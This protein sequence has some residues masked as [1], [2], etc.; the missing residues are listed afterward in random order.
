MNAAAAICLD[1]MSLRK[2]HGTDK[3]PSQRCEDAPYL[4]GHEPDLSFLPA[5]VVLP[6]TIAT[7]GDPTESDPLSTEPKRALV[8]W[9]K[10]FWM[11]LKAFGTLPISLECRLPSAMNVTLLG[12]ICY[13]LPN[14]D[15]RHYSPVP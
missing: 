5:D 12:E 7:E 4:V 10:Y 11:R 13:N 15:L 6:T 8:E 14:S 1:C 3:D 2:C 9:F